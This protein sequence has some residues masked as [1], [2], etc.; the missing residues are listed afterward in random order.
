MVDGRWSMVD[1]RWSMVDGRWS[2]VDGRWSMVDGRWSMVDGVARALRQASLT[3][4]RSNCW[5]GLGPYIFPV[6]LHQGEIRLDKLGLDACRSH[7]RGSDAPV[8]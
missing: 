8:D 4:R 5:A 3:Y 2:M 1:G 7:G 6:V